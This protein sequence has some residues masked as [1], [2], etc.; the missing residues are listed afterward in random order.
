MRKLFVILLFAVLALGV[1]PVSVW[2]HEP[3]IDLEKLVSVDGGQTFVDADTCDEAPTTDGP[4][5]YKLV[6]TNCGDVPLTYFHLIDEALGIDTWQFA[7]IVLPGGMVAFGTKELI[8]ELSVEDV[9]ELGNVFENVAEVTAYDYN[10]REVSDS[11]PA[12]VKCAPFCGDGIVGPG[13]TC[14]PPGSI[15]DGNYPDNLCRDTCTYCGDG[16]VNNGEACD[17]NAPNAP[18]NCTQDCTLPFCG[19]GI[20]GPD[21]TCDPPGSIPDGNY[22]DNVCR[23]TCTYCGDGIVNNGEECDFNAPN[24]P[25]NCTQDCTLPPECVLEVDKKCLVE[26]PPPGPF[27]C[28]DAKPID[29]LTMKWGGT[30]EISEIA[31][32]RDKYDPNDPAKNL[33]YIIPGPIVTGQEVTADGYAA[34]KAPNDVDWHIFFADGSDGISRFHRSCSDNDMNGPEDC[35]KNEGNAKT[36]DS[37]FVNDWLFEGMAGKLTLDCTPEPTELTEPTDECSFVPAPPPDCDAL[38]KPKSLTFRYTGSD[39]SASSNNQAS[40]KWDCSGVPGPAPVS[41][42]IVKDVNKITV[43]PMSGINTGDLVT[44]SAIGSETGSE[45]QLYVGGQFLKIHTSCSQ[46]LAEGDQFGSMKVVDLI[47]VPK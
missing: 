35:G 13:E 42:G 43:S 39:C 15:P 18:P 34:A 24:A 31:I 12:C 45:I 36:T 11:D 5:E 33:M 37:S 3:C 28:S 7:N 41:I 27:V 29:S 46:P 22:P 16:I 44:V 17:F 19:D 6:V 10:W 14:D 4:A 26:K 20:V 25:P 47:L 38:G 9:C 23:D 8:P 40:D 2:A 32:Y 21:E 1:L 30:K